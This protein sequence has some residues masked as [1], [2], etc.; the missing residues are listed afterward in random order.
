MNPRKTKVLVLGSSG[1]VG[2]KTA[3][4]LDES[5]EIDV[6]ITSRKKEEVER[7]RLLGKDAVYLDLN[8]ERLIAAASQTG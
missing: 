8:R 5:P 4:I 1:Q 3:A 6:R 2:G 7:L